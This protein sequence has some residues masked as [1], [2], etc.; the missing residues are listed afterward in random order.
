[1]I[2]GGFDSGLMLYLCCLIKQQENLST[3]FVVF[4]V[5]RHDDSISHANR[6]V[7]WINKKF[8]NS[9]EIFTVGDPNLHHSQ[10]VYSGVKDAYGCCEYIV[11]S[12]TTN[13]AHLLNGPF[14]SRSN[15]LDVIHPFFNLT[16]KDTVALAIELELTD[17]MILSHTCTESVLL[18]C[19]KCWQC[20]ERAWGFSENNYIDPGT[21]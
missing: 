20:Q 12:D 6:I 21:M 13:P 11:L 17:L 8:D 3:T 1:M 2:S 4:T 14:R 16:K 7:D 19:G 5:P 9:L 15:Q 10:Q 18:R